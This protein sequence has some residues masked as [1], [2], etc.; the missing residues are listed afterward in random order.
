MGSL[1]LTCITSLRQR[2]TCDV[3]RVSHVTASA[4]D[5]YRLPPNRINRE[6]RRKDHAHDGERL[7][8]TSRVFDAFGCR[9]TSNSHGQVTIRRQPPCA[10]RMQW[11]HRM[12]HF[13]AVRE[14]N[15]GDISETVEV[16]AAACAENG[17]RAERSRAGCACT[18]WLHAASPCSSR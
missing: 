4:S 12:R 6:Q 11:H 9:T 1:A 7:E 15:L 3:P 2:V 14:P 10:P 5:I 13:K 18:P 16:A 8:K 17:R